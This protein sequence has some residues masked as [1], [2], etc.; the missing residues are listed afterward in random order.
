[1]FFWTGSMVSRQQ[2]VE[3]YIFI[4]AANGYNYSGQALSFLQDKR[5]K[6]KTKKSSTLRT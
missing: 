5:L 6:I 4:N 1:M 2:K 3:R